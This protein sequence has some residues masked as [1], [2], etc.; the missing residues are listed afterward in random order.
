MADLLDDIIT[1]VLAN[2]SVATAYGTD[3]FKDFTPPTPD[4]LVTVKEYEGSM[5]GMQISG[6]T[7]QIQIQGVSKSYSTAKTKAQAIFNLLR[8]EEIVNL[9]A[10]RWCVVYIST[11]PVKQYVDEQSR[12]H[13][14]FNVSMTTYTD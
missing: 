1:Y 5:P 8:S 11:P 14:G 12:V 2:T 10:E 3:I 9:T 6:A 7:R 13:F 4:S